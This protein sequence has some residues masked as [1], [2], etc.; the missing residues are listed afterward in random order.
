MAMTDQHSGVL[1]LDV[2]IRDAVLCHVLLNARTARTKRMNRPKSPGRHSQTVL[3]IARIV[4]SDSPNEALTIGRLS[5]ARVI[6]EERVL[7]QQLEV[8]PQQKPSR[9]RKMT[10]AS[11]NVV[12]RTVIA[13]LE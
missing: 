12:L 2:P 6:T 4:R 8:R 10:D 1:M 3:N 11:R 13:M 7:I 9:M 5:Q